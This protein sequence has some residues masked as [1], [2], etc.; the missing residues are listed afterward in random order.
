MT[1]SGIEA[2]YTASEQSHVVVETVEKSASAPRHAGRPLGAGDRVRSHGPGLSRASLD[3][4][5]HFSIDASQAGELCK[6]HKFCCVV[7]LR[8]KLRVAS[9]V[10]LDYR[11]EFENF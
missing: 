7:L 3:G 4:V 10:F 1:G 11:L 9:Y 8:K 5:N 6:T 2:P